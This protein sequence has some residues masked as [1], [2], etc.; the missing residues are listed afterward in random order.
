VAVVVISVALL[1]VAVAVGVVDVVTVAGE[2]TAAPVVSCE[3]SSP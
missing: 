3:K 1:V 2:V